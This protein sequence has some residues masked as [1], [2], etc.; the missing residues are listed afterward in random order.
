MYV[1]KSDA[2]P[3]DLCIDQRSGSFKIQELSSAVASI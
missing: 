3:I 2:V 1:P